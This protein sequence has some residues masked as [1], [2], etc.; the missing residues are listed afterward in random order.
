MQTEATG[1]LRAEDVTVYPSSSAAQPHVEIADRLCLLSARLRCCFPLTDP[2]SHI[3]V[4][5]SES[6]EYGIISD[7]ADLDVSSRA[8]VEH[9]LD[10][11]YFTP[12]IGRIRS[13]R[14]EASMW[15]WSVET[16]RGDA[17]FYLRGVRD[18]VHEVAPGRWQIYSVDGQRYEIRNLDELDSRSQNLF[19]SLF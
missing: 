13:L 9:A 6:R 3:V 8:A 7:L 4:L 11:F 5:D 14:Q 19:E 2:R 18:S 16:Q 17:E 10:A 12:S 1:F 15:K